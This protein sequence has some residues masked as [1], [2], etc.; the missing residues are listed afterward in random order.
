MKE[1]PTGGTVRGDHQFLCNRD[2]FMNS[3]FMGS[4]AE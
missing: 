1:L 4:S 2:W 3:S